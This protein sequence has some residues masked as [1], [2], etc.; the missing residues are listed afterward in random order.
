MSAKISQKIPMCL[1]LLNP[2]MQ[3]A[4]LKTCYIF[5]AV[6]KITAYLIVFIQ[7]CFSATATFARY[8]RRVDVQN[9]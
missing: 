1:I 9:M 3:I 4:F 8:L 2:T 7:L 6:S 5:L